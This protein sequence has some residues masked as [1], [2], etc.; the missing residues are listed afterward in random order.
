MA[1]TRESHGSFHHV[2]F[3]FQLFGG[4]LQLGGGLILGLRGLVDAGWET[5]QV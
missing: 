1:G 3:C 2:V 4:G 5:A